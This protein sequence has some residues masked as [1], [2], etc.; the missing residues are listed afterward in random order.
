MKPI[1]DIGISNNYCFVLSENSIEIFNTFDSKKFVPVQSV[2]VMGCRGL[3]NGRVFA[4]SRDDA[5]YLYEVPYETQIKNLLS[6]CKV[7]Q[8]L[9]VLIQN[10]G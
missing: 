8:A 2:D 5:V 4:F 1:T 3:T 7:E 10:V 6:N 9:Q